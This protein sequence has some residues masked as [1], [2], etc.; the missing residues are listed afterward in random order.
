MSETNKYR[1]GIDPMPDGNYQENEDGTWSPAVPLGIVGPTS[2]R[3]WLLGL[4]R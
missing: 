2:W 4:F 3:E 1:R